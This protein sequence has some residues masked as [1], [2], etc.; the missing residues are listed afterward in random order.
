MLIPH[1]DPGSLVSAIETL[2]QDKSIREKYS[3]NGLETVRTK[4]SIENQVEQLTELY[5]DILSE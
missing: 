4:F 2:I 1:S 3:V 5:L